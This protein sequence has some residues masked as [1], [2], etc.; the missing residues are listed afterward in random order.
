MGDYE[1]YITQELVHQID[2]SYR[3]LPNRESRGVMGCSMGGT[4]ALHLGLKYP[5]V[6][7]VA[8]PMS[9]AIYDI[10]NDPFWEIARSE[11]SSEPMNMADLNLLPEI[12]IFFAIAA[13][14]APNPN[15]P[16]FYLDMPFANVNGKAQIVPEVFQKVNALDPMNDVIN[17]LSQPMRLRGLLIFTDT[18]RE[19]VPE[20]AEFNMEAVRRFDKSLTELGIEHLY[21]EVDAAHC[22]F[23]W[24]PILEFM[25]TN[26]VY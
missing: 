26:L 1:T 14:A 21:V 16:P 22:S 11:F 5:N 23:D 12:K 7:G 4:G 17:Y 18:D 9:A 8:A 15:K 19:D 3:T 6:F 24:S 13:G 2:A 10:E 25:G 20:L